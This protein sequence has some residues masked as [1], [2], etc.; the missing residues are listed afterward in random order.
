MA[1]ATVRLHQLAGSA[2]LTA[3]SDQSGHY[4]FEDVAAGDYLLDATAPGLSAL[5]SVTVSLRAGEVRTIPV[6]LAVS[7]IRTQVS[8]T[9]ASEPQALDQV[10]KALDV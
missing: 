4:I 6:E 1:S 3:A 2:L 5:Q 7:A 10:S 9:A 8:V